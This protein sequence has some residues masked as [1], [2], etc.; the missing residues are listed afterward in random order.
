M[1]RIQTAC[2]LTVTEP[3]IDHQTVSH[4]GKVNDF[5]TLMVK[6]PLTICLLTDGY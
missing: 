2:G 4:Y 5:S 3:C 6:I 1:L